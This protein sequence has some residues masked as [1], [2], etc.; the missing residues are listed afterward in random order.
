V[1]L[2]I[3]LGFFLLALQFLRKLFM[4]FQSIRHSDSLH[5]ISPSES[6]DGAK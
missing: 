3:P 2:V 5:E 6:S 4:A 1:V